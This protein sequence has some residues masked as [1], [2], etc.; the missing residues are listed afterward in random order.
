MGM[1]EK[2]AS[3]LGPETLGTSRT[4]ETSG[5]PGTPKNP[6][7]LQD[8][9]EPREPMKP[10]KALVSLGIPG[11]LGPLGSR[12]L[13]Y[14]RIIWTPRTPR[15]FGPSDLLGPQESWE[16]EARTSS[17]FCFPPAPSLLSTEITIKDIWLDILRLKKSVNFLHYSMWKYL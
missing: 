7:G 3:V 1:L 5:T 17:P 2:W 11:P 16:I 4:L 8:L 12:D 9:Q 15:T 14:L 13:Q 10:T 6:W